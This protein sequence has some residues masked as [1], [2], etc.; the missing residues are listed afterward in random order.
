MMKCCE[1]CGALLEDDALACP[2]CGTAYE[3]LK[4]TAV[5]VQPQT[6]ETVTPL[7]KKKLNKKTILFNNRKLFKK[8]RARL[9][10]EVLKNY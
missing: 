2:H 6:E 8:R 9:H 5:A 4:E 1:H 7:S 3:T 10:Q